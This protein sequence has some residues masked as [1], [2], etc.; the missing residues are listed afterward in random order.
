LLPDPND[1]ACMSQEPSDIQSPSQAVAYAD[2]PPSQQ[3]HRLLELAAVFLRLGTIAFGDPA[4][5]IAMMDDEDD[6][7]ERKGARGS[8][9]FHRTATFG[10][11][12]SARQA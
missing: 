9:I 8:C 1:L 2:L 11:N 4:A 6:S 12:C 7:L 10:W 5:H 3:R